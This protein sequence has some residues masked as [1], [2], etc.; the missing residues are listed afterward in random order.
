MR[1]FTA[2]DGAKI[3]VEVNSAEGNTLAVLMIHGFTGNVNEHIFYNAAQLWPKKGLDVWR[4]SLYPGEIKGTR[5]MKTVTWAQNLGDINLVL[6]EM[7]NL[8]GKLFLVGHSM[9]GTQAVYVNDP[10]LGAKVLWDPSCDSNPSD[11]IEPELHPD[12]YTIDW[13][14][15]ILAKKD[16]SHEAIAAAKYPAERLTECQPPIFVIWSDENDRGWPQK[17]LKAKVV[18]IKGSDHCFNGE[19]NEK[20]LFSR[21]LNFFKKNAGNFEVA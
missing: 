9:G 12:Y 4:I 14:H 5:S 10:K 16:Y 13:V 19:G 17:T 2:P 20:K 18:K 21:T 8:Y 3:V 7:A 15:I 11:V 1:E 6:K